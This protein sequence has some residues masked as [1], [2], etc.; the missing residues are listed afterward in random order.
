MAKGMFAAAK[1]PPGLAT[2]MA[3]TALSTLSLNM[4]LPSL[5]HIAEDFQADYSLVS[6]SVAGYLGVTAVLQLIIGPLSD[7]FGRRPVLLW[8]LSLFG[9]ASL[10]CAL[11]TNIL[12]FLAFRMLQ[13]AMIAGYALSMA[14]VR[15]IVSER[16]AA[17]LIGYISMVMALAPMIGPTLGGA[18]D[19]L[20]GWR[21]I[22]FFYLGSGV[23]LFVLCWVDL[24]ETHK[25]PTETLGGRA[26]S[27]SELLRSKRFWSYGL[28]MTFSTGAFYSFIAGAPLVAETMFSM[29]SAA[30]GLALGSITGGF[31]L[32]SF[33]SGRFAPRYSLAT[34]MLAGRIIACFGLMGGIA[35]LVGGVVTIVTFFGAAVFVGLGNGLTMPSSNAGVLSVRPRL[36]GS[37]AGLAGA[38][39]VAGGGIISAITG[40]VLT[41]ENG[42]YVLLGLMLATSFAG[43]LAAFSAQQLDGAALRA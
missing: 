4:F 16:K 43:L 31:V 42:A 30:L 33:L 26:R 40:A 39:T 3:L 1:S 25:T 19:T 15:D 24:G 7:H 14:I 32:G 20:F 21:A 41:N 29:S 38:L 23:A 11:S 10:V 8:A 5:A 17:G 35:L 12:V 27:Y 37:A 13:G 18:L 28:C 9:V 6:L 2:L 22:F 34:T 36:A